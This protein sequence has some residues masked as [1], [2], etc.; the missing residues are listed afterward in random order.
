MPVIGAVVSFYEPLVT[1]ITVLE[2]TKNPKIH[3]DL[4]MLSRCQPKL[5]QLAYDASDVTL[6]MVAHRVNATLKQ[7]ACFVPSQEV[8]GNS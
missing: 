5:S 2:G 3:K 7:N 8:E 1:T 4:P 6:S